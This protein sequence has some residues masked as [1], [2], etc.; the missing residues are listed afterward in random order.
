MST[1]ANTNH[2]LVP[3]Y[4]WRDY[5]RQIRTAL[6]QSAVM[7]G[8]M[9]SEMPFLEHLEELRTRLLRSL[10]AVAIGMCICLAYATQLILFLRWPADV[11]GIRLV[12]IEATDV[13]SLYFRVGLSGGVCLAAPFVLWQVWRFIEPALYRHEKRYA[14]PFLIS[15]VVCFIGGAVFGYAVVSPWFLRLQAAMAQAAHF[16]QTMSALSYFGLLTTLVISMGAIF[17]MPA[18]VLILSRIGLISAGFLLRHCKYALLL[19]SVASAILTPSTTDIAPMIA[20]TAVMTGVYAIS[21]LVAFVF[22][23]ARSVERAE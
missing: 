1:V 18:I 16:E 23:K 19:F 8:A 9:L 10:I 5:M 14:A 20:F 2:G 3:G 17:E 7:A 21:I 13:F 22:G 6:F 12:P 11:V 4:S 15:T